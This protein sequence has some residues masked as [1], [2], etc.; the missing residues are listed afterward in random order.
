MATDAMDLQQRCLRSL[1]RTHGM[2]LSNYG[3]RPGALDAGCAAHPPP[4][5]HRRPLSHRSS[6]QPRNSRAEQAPWRKFGVLSRAGDKVGDSLPSPLLSSTLLSFVYGKFVYGSPRLHRVCDAMISRQACAG[7]A[8]A[9]EQHPTGT[10]P[11]ERVP[12]LQV[13]GAVPEK[14]RQFTR[15]LARRASP[16]MMSSTILGDRGGYRF[17]RGFARNFLP[18]TTKLR[19]TWRN[20]RSADAVSFY[21]VRE[22]EQ[23]NRTLENGFGTVWRRAGLFGWGAMPRRSET[24]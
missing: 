16:C 22:S 10:R 19:R 7:G 21:F 20:R 11:L 13:G 18:R 1:K 17:T 8:G 24:V 15:C 3:Q 5:A 14:S 6:A 12:V 4:N 9:S 23:V 2:Y